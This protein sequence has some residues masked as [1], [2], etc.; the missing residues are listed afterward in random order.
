MDEVAR[1]IRV[2]STSR[3]ISAA[4]RNPQLGLGVDIPRPVDLFAP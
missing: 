2:G 3:S 1:S 4:I